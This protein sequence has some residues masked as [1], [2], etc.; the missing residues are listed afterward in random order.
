MTTSQLDKTEINPV[1]NRAFAALKARAAGLGEG[2]VFVEPDLGLGALPD[3]SGVADALDQS[4]WEWLHE[5]L[6]L[7]PLPPHDLGEMVVPIAV[8]HVRYR[9]PGRRLAQAVLRARRD[10]AEIELPPAAAFD[11]LFAPRTA[12]AASAAL[13]PAYW[14]F[15]RRPDRYPGLKVRFRLSPEHFIASGPGTD[16]PP[17]P[18]EIDFDDGEGFRSL[19]WGDEALVEYEAAGQQRIALRLQTPTGSLNAAFLFTVEEASA[20]PADEVAPVTASL[21]HEKRHYG[22]T[23]HVYYAWGNR[24]GRVQKPILLAE[25]FPGGAWANDI[26]D[27]FDGK[28]PGGWN[29]NAKLAN[30]LRDAGFDLIILI[31]G[32]PGAP[33]QGNAM[34]YLEALKWIRDQVGPS[35]EIAAMGGSMGGLIARY[36]LCY[37]ETHGTDIGNVT[38]MVTFDSPHVGANVPMAV[39]YTARFYA[40]RSHSF[41]DLLNY[42]CAKQMLMHQVWYREDVEEEVVKE[43]YRRFYAELEAM[44]KDGYPTRPKKY[45]VSNGHLEGFDLVRPESH[46]LT[47]RRRSGICA[48]YEAH[49]WFTANRAPQPRYD[50]ADCW[51]S[52]RPHRIV[53]Y[54][55]PS[56]G[57]FSRDGCAGGF[58]NHVEKA[59]DAL[60]PFGAFPEGYMTTGRNCFVPAYSALGVKWAGDAHQFKPS[61]HRGR[62]PFDDWYAPATNQWH[63]TIDKSIKEWVLGLFS[64]HAAETETLEAAV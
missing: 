61:Q 15:E 41:H 51:I 22:G 9:A 18:V 29:P 14:G 59:K 8:F 46:A 16:L 27:I 30:E 48:H 55:K 28:T 4:R 33:I 43:D 24:S 34:V 62:T 64:R 19:N 2:P 44:R 63:C 5:Q 23:R 21:A 25:G 31:F 6:G 3:G 42:A 10:D 57:F 40:H 47:V 39:Q 36:A 35:T 53:A 50:Y 49:L 37:A 54:L 56:A 12:F 11:E 45:A 20:P 38:R 32:T 58:A 1:F 13:P 7:P 17:G 60:S 26:Y 52:D